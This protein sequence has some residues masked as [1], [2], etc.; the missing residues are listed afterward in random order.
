MKKVIAFFLLCIGQFV[1]VGHGDA[2][3]ATITGKITSQN[4]AVE[5]ATVSVNDKSDFTDV[6][7]KYRL[8]DVPYGQAKIV[9]TKGDKK[10]E[11]DI[12]VDGPEKTQDIS[13]E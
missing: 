1:V 7:G 2:Q 9:I 3:T 13:L 6:D 11:V 8:K 4:A 10:K 5:K 12:Q